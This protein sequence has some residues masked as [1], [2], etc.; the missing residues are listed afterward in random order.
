MVPVG[1]YFLVAKGTIIAAMQLK[2]PV[3]NHIS[4]AIEVKHAATIIAISELAVSDMT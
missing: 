2:F 3:K 4:K 1:L